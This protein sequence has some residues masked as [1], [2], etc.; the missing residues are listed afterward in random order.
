MAQADAGRRVVLATF[1]SLGDLHPYLAIAAAL[2]GRGHRPLVAATD[3]HRAAVEA[4]GIEFRPLAPGAAA[5][6]DERTAMARALDPATGPGFV[7]RDVLMG[8]LREAHADL[9]AACDGADL[10]VSHPFTFAAPLVAER[11]RAAGLAWASVAISPSVLPSAHDPAVLAP[12]PWLRHLRPLGPAFHRL[13]LKAVRAR[14]RGWMAPWH[15]LRRELGLAPTAAHP[16]FEAQF[17]PDLVLAL[18]PAAF[19]APQPDWPARTVVAGFVAARRRGEAETLPP[20]L[21]AFLA[22]GDAPLVFTLGSAAV[23]GAGDFYVQSVEAARRLGRRALLLVGSDARNRAAIAAS[24]QVAL[25]EY[26]PH[27]LVF[28]RAAA[29]VHQGGIG[30]TA[31]ALLAGRPMLVVP[32]GFDQP[33]N[34]ARAE[35]LGVALAL[36]RRRYDAGRA[37]RALQALLEDPS[38]AV[39]AGEVA[40]RVA[41]ADG[42]SNACDAIERLLAGCTA[43]S[44]RAA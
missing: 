21:E 30:T 3:I 38:H 26:V 4:E 14:T 32:F 22:A 40:R 15:A 20:V 35:R 10:L 8:H 25:A 27:A 5:F 19:A 18:F 43:G 42:T 12:A 9:D 2:R 17:S 44:G 23:H 41:A 29:I 31:Q 37:A 11:R 28:P 16:L 33:D 1:G 36:P 13:L 34:A 39:R 24:P 6:G 7:V